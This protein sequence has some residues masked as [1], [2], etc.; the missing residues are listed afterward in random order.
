MHVLTKKEHLTFNINLFPC[1]EIVEIF[2][3]PYAE[4]LK[5]KE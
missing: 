5:E 2:Y 3:T 1:I 4:N